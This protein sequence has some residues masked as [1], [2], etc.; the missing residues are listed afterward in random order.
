MHRSRCRCCCFE[1]NLLLGVSAS[2]SSVRFRIYGFDVDFHLR[3]QPICPLLALWRSC[4]QLRLQLQRFGRQHR[5][6]STWR[7]ALLEQIFQLRLQPAKQGVNC[8][9]TSVLRRFL[10]ERAAHDASLM[11]LER[12]L[13]HADER[14]LFRVARSHAARWKQYVKPEDCTRMLSVI[15]SAER[16]LI[17]TNLAH[18][19]AP[20]PPIATHGNTFPAWRCGGTCV[21]STS[22]R[23]QPIFTFVLTFVQ[24]IVQNRTQRHKL[25]GSPLRKI[26]RHL[27]IKRRH[28]CINTQRCVLCSSR[29]FIDSPAPITP[30]RFTLS[31]KRHCGG[32]GS[33]M[34]QTGEHRAM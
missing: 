3:K 16:H 21:S 24:V 11:G 34:C 28:D 25:I 6:R 2:N 18:A 32:C 12:R 4:E 1:N 10:R 9:L 19:H 8:F 17:C 5:C 31:T 13:A 15:G 22:S 20:A 7:E 33:E 23:T 27:S 29:D 30:I 14:R 26:F